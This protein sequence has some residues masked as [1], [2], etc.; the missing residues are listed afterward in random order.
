MWRKS[1]RRAFSVHQ[2]SFL[3]A[4]DHVLLD[5]GDVVRDVVDEMHVQVVRRAVEHFA[6]RLQRKEL[7]R[8]RAIAKPGLWEPE[9]FWAVEPE[10]LWVAGVEHF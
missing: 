3:L 10:Q 4:V 9:Q 7:N 1:A 5:L 2:Q 8:Q 6:E